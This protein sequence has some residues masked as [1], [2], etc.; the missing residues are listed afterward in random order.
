M[1][2]IRE[3]LVEITGTSEYSDSL[4]DD[5]ELAGSGI[6]SGDLVRL[7]LLVEE[8]T[9]VAVTAADMETL[10]TIGEYERF[11]A[12]RTGAGTSGGA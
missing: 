7:L 8:R 5:D 10:G 11:V 2:R 9:G 6:D 4:S 1:S 12:E 3:M